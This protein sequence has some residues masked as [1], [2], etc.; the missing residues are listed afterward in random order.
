MREKNA[1]RKRY[2]RERLPTKRVAE[3]KEKDKTRKRKE[4][5]NLSPVSRSSVKK[6]HAENEKRRVASKTTETQLMKKRMHADMEWFR[7]RALPV[8]E[9]KRLRDKKTNNQKERRARMTE[10]EKKKQREKDAKRKRD[11]R[12]ANKSFCNKIK[13]YFRDKSQPMPLW[14][15]CDSYMEDHNMDITKLNPFP[16]YHTFMVDILWANHWTF[17][18]QSLYLV[19][20]RQ[21]GTKQL[22]AKV[23]RF[24]WLKNFFFLFF[25]LF[26]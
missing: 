8:E 26:C 11:K 10:E 6:R 25:F 7:V 15:L 14:L 19:P 1:E 12:T 2:W 5:A 23:C 22:H 4:R 18:C 24:E 17:T 16:K 21:L 3:L 9:K 13:G 20:T